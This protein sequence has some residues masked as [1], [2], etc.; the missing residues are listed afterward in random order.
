MT[1]RDVSSDLIQVIFP[2]PMQGVLRRR[3]W[4]ECHPPDNYLNHGSADLQRMQGGLMRLLARA[5]F[6]QG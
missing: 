2:V 3:R 1:M 6:R 4:R 5:T